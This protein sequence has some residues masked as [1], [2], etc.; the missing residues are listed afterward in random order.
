VF[1]NPETEV[2]KQACETC[3]KYVW[4]FNGAF[5]SDWRACD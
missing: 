5:D 2:A 3:Q 1:N 4:A